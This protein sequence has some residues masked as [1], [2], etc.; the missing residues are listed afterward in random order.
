VLESQGWVYPSEQALALRFQDLTG[1]KIDYQIVPSANYFQVLNTKLNS[2]QG[3]DIFGGQSG[4]S[5]LKVTYNVEKNAVDLTDQEWVKREDPNAVS[6]A[7]LNGKVYG[8]EIWDIYSGYWIITYSKSAFQKAG[9]TDVPKTYD[10]FTADCDKIKAAGVTPIYEP[11]SDGW[12]HVLW[13]PEVGAQMENVEPGF[14]ANLNANKTTLA[15]DPN[16]LKAMTQLGNLYSKG[17][18][19]TSALSAT[20]ADQEKNM[21]TGKFAMTVSNLTLPQSIQTD[22]PSFKAS[23]YGYFPIPLLDNQLLPTHPA[24]PTKFIWSGGKQID[25]AKQYLAFLAQPDSLQYL[26]DNTDAFATLDFSG[27]K[28][29]WSADQ[30]AFMSK[31]TAA[32]VNVLQDDVMYVN[33]QWMDIGKDEVAMFTGKETPLQVLQAI[34]KRRA[35]QATTAKDPAWSK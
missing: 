19:G 14:Y 10:E 21:T 17:Y 5:D 33:P 23:D 20:V 29:K 18:M 13:F 31:Y 6:Q 27:V 1:I 7:T 26:I 35:T 12:H 32:K 11:I 4:V 25:A 8:Q 30:Q 2:G 16:A 28:A 3:P 34:D 22:F 9:I 15:A 24:G